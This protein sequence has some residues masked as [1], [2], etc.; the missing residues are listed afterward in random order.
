MNATGSR[1][2]RRAIAA[3]KREPNPSGAGSRLCASSRAL[4]QPSTWRASTSASKAA[5][6]AA[7]PAA[8]SRRRP[9]GD[10]LVQLHVCRPRPPQGVAGSLSAD[11][12]SFSDWSWATA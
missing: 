6:S 2:A 10:L 11:A 3:S 1:L 5:V 8:T 12:L 9:F 4:S 7:N